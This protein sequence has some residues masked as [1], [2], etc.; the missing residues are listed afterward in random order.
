MP[1]LSGGPM[2]NGHYP[3]STRTWCKCLIINVVSNLSGGNL[4]ALPDRCGSS[5]SVHWGWWHRWMRWQ[6]P[7]PCLPAVSGASWTRRAPVS[8]AV[9]RRTP[10]TG[11]AAAREQRHETGRTRHPPRL[12][13]HRQFYP[14]LPPLDELLP[15]R[16]PQSHPKNAGRNPFLGSDPKGYFRAWLRSAIRSLASSRPTDRR[17]MPSPMPRLRR[18][19]WLRPWWLVALGWLTRLSTPPRLVASRKIFRESATFSAA[20]WP[21]STSMLSMPPKPVICCWARS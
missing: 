13:R 7:W 5:Y 17:S 15:R 3:P 6:D 21:P 19:S 12:H 18:S 14:S 2:P 16:I 4:E 1:W 20:C 10:P 11:V 9:G 8:Q